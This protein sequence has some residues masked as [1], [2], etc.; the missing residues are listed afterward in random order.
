MPLTHRQEAPNNM[1]DSYT[2]NNNTRIPK[3]G[4]GT[5]QTP[6]DASGVE[7]MVNAIQLGYRHID[8]AQSY[9]NEKSVGAAIA[10]AQ[11]ARDE[12]FITTKVANSVNGYEQ[13]LESLDQSLVDLGLEYL[14][15]VLIHWPSPQRYRDQW[16]SRNREVWRALETYYAEG[17]I[18]A[19]GISNFRTHHIAE[20]LKTA[21]VLPAVNQIRLCPGDVDEETVA[22]CRK[23][24]M[25]LEAYSPL[26]QGLIF[27]V[28]EIAVMAAKYE[29]TPAQLALRWSLQMG[30]LPLPKTV[31][32]E[33]MQSNLSIFDFELDQ[34][35]VDL[36]THLEGKAGTAKDPDSVPF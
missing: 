2:L 27:D 34:D 19:I 32:I 15:M 21:T 12:L 22:V 8:T 25:L 5:F 13:T 4:Y 23:H 17:K 24:N 1:L 33:R 35:D 9:R 20:L 18:K 7:A 28:E 26:G 3:L 6:D 36:L 11:V 30:F 29:K 31:S 16:Q 14:D 10:L